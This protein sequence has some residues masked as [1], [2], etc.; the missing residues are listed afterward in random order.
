MLTGGTWLGSG[1][2]NVAILD[3]FLP[4]SATYNKIFR[5]AQQ[6]KIESTETF[7]RK[8][9]TTHAN[10]IKFQDALKEYPHRFGFSSED[11]NL[12][13]FSKNDFKDRHYG[14]Y[15]EYMSNITSVFNREDPE[16]IMYTLSSQRMSKC[17]DE[18]LSDR[19]IDFLQ[20]SLIILGVKKIAHRDCFPRNILML[21]GNPV[22]TDWDF[23]KENASTAELLA[24]RS[25]LSYFRKLLRPPMF[26]AALPAVVRAVPALPT[27]VFLSASSQNLSSRE[28]SG[29]GNN[30]GGPFDPFQLEE[31]APDLHFNKE[32]TSEA[33]SLRINQIRAFEFNLPELEVVPEGEEGSTA[34]NMGL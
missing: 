27:A 31:N 14:V 3:D 2:F 8:I 9:Q 18:G 28:I 29:L 10:E 20:A 13:S 16:V 7:I 33:T 22:L 34:D 25:I 5:I 32:I 4:V 19:Q 6:K 24:D 23:A 17:P 1:S 21:N 11:G 15:E 30:L 12:Y 26:A